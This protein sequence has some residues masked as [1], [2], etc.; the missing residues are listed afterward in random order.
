VK[1]DTIEH[2]TTNFEPWNWSWGPNTCSYRRRS[3]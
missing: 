3:M 1:G 2:R